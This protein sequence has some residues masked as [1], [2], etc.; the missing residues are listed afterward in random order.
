MYGIMT[1]SAVPFTG[2]RSS[3]LPITV[4]SIGV[5]LLHYW[6]AKTIN[7]SDGEQVVS[8]ASHVSDALMSTSG[9][10][11]KLLRE[12]SGAPY[13]RF[14]AA[15]SESL[16]YQAPR[17]QPHTVI[18]KLRIRTTPPSG[19]TAGISGAAGA[20]SRTVIR[21]NAAGVIQAGD[22]GDFVD[23]EPLLNPATEWHTMIAEFN[24]SNSAITVDGITITGPMGSGVPGEGQ[25][26]TIGRGNGT[27]YS[28]ID[29]KQV[30][31]LDRVL[32]SEER[33]AVYFAGLERP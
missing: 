11:P 12:T 25:A 6:D 19:V 8:W 15:A 24:G 3:K 29:V 17:P 28:D 30:G 18:M 10:K 33:Q 2:P 7:I 21:F 4:P 13:I 22:G 5:P 26:L 23:S 27:N 14:T 32:T 20:T 31:Y 1:E 9:A 16:T